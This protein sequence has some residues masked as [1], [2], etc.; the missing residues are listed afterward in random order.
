MTLY[1]YIKA[2]AEKYPYFPMER[3]ARR[4]GFTLGS[5]KP[6]TENIKGSDVLMTWTPWRDTGRHKRVLAFA[7]AGARVLICENGFIPTIGGRRYWQV[8]I[9]GVNGAGRFPV[10]GPERWASWGV[11][12]KPWRSG[13]DYILVCAQRGTVEDDPAITHGSWWPDQILAKIR[14]VTDRP[15]LWRSHPGAPWRGH[16]VGWEG[17]DVTVA[18]YGV[19]LAEH[20]AGAIACIVYTSTSATEALIDGV[21]TFYDGPQIMLKDAALP[22]SKLYVLRQ[23]KGPDTSIDCDDP[24]LPMKGGPLAVPLHAHFPD[25]RAAFERAAWGQWSDDELALGK[26]LKHLG[27]LP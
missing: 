15:I 3:G 18:P 21:P 6:P 12:L 16:P 14:A 19:P 17:R 4:L 9:D 25:R 5:G 13:G 2:D 24:D 22:T 7:K 11:E 1:L 26:H 8:G 20:L 10:G 27:V 23:T